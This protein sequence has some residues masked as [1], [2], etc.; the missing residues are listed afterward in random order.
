MHQIAYDGQALKPGAV[1]AMKKI[2]ARRVFR[3]F[4]DHPYKCN[5]A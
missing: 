3:F 2:P 1:G 4:R 5:Q